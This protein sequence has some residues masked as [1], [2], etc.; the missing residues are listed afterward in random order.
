MTLELANLISTLMIENDIY[1]ELIIH[2]DIGTVGKTKELIAEIK[3][4]VNSEG[5]TAYIKPEAY[6]ACAIANLI[7]K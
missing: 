2:V 1:H 6:A 5:Y 7:S 3:G 4:W